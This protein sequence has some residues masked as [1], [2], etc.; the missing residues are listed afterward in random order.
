VSRFCLLVMFNA[1]TGQVRDYFAHLVPLVERE[2]YGRDLVANDV[3]ELDP[4]EWAYVGIER[5]APPRKPI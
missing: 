3:D 1:R 2:D 4:A 5:A